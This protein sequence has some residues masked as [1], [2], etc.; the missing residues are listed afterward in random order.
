[1]A[2][3]IVHDMG[4]GKIRGYSLGGRKDIEDGLVEAMEP[5]AGRGANS[6]SYDAFFGSDHFDFLLEGIPTL[7]AMQDTTTYV[8]YYHSA[9]DTYEKVDLNALRDAAA[10]AA[11]TVFNVADLPHRLGERLNRRQLEELMVRTDLDDQLKFLGL[12]D[13]WKEGRRGRDPNGR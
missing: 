11:V 10:I 9:A 4:V 1:V 12:W 7:I 2:A 13:E 3:V 8:P 6:H 5:V